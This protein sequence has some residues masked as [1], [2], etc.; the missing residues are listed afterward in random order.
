MWG[1][2]WASFGICGESSL[3]RSK[4]V[5]L[6]F[7]L[8]LG[9]SKLFSNLHTSTGTSDSKGSF[10]YSSQCVWRAVIPWD[11]PGAAW[12]CA[13]TRQ[14]IVISPLLAQLALLCLALHDTL[15]IDSCE[16][17][18]FLF[19]MFICLLLLGDVTGT[20]KGMG[21]TQTLLKYMKILLEPLCAS[22]LSQPSH[23]PTFINLAYFHDFS[24]STRYHIVPLLY[25]ID[26]DTRTRCRDNRCY[27]WM[28]LILIGN[29][30][31]NGCFQGASSM[32]RSFP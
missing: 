1:H 17:Y 29:D 23:A 12:I 30:S 11:L 27:L 28:L 6:S 22:D 32:T 5:V 10:D 20:Q 26:F 31:Q 13:T 14:V 8:E 2:L 19:W 4:K 3:W 21:T 7:L 9:R 16:S 25:G 24:H 18:S 15:F